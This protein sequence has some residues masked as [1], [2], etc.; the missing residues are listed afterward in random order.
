MKKYITILLGFCAFNS[1]AQKAFFGSQ[2]TEPSRFVQ[3]TLAAKVITTGLIQNLDAN[4][5]TSYGG[6]G[7]IWTDLAGTNHGSIVGGTFTTSGGVSFF[8]FPTANVPSYVSAPLAKTPSMTF[9]IWAKGNSATVP[10]CMLFN[11]GFAAVGPDLFFSGGGIYWNV[12]DGGNTPF[13]DALNATV[14]TSI[15]ANTNWHN[16]TVVVDEAG[17]NAKLYFDGVWMGTSAYR[18]PTAS[19]ALFIGSAGINSGGINDASW[20][21]LGG[22]S[23]FQ[24]YNRALS[25]SEVT[26]NF[27]ALKSRFGFS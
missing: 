27:N 24:S 1:T 20:N 16:Y 9:S 6:S 15:A 13:R 10:G 23:I 8:N 12:W 21:W 5:S 2:N 17:N 11:A 19:T 7:N 4:N 22:I 3:S 18:S 14:S 25:A 26:A